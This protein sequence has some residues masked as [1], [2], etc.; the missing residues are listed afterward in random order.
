MESEPEKLLVIPSTTWLPP[1]PEED[2]VEEAFEHFAAALQRNLFRFGEDRTQQKIVHR[3][4]PEEFD[5][6]VYNVNGSINDIDL[7][8]ASDIRTE[9][10]KK[11]NGE[12]VI[13]P[14]ED[15][16]DPLSLVNESLNEL[17]QEEREVLAIDVVGAYV[18]GIHVM[19]NN[20]SR[21]VINETEYIEFTKSRPLALPELLEEAHTLYER[22]LNNDL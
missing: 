8:V 12:L 20:W 13:E 11:K 3:L 10:R 2:V 22:I 17:E 7:R 21:G 16:V 15:F 19:F 5:L 9:I 1:L 6:F 14:Y 18:Q 4:K